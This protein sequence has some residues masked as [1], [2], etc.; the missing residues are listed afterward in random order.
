MEKHYGI[1]DT[2]VEIGKKYHYGF[3][4]EKNRGM[5]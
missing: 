5:E 4:Q 2:F 1:M 3:K